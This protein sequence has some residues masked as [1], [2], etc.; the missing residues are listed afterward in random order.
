MASLLGTGASHGKQRG[1]RRRSRLAACLLFILAAYL[2]IAFS[3]CGAG[4]ADIGPGPPEQLGYIIK[5]GALSRVMLTTT[6]G[7]AGESL[8]E[9]PGFGERFSISNDG[10]YFTIVLWRED[11][12]FEGHATSLIIATDGSSGLT[13][14][15]D[16]VRP[17]F[18]P[19][20]SSVAYYTMAT[21]GP[22]SSTV[23]A[24][25]I[26]SGRVTA[27][28]HGNILE[29][30]VWSDNANIVYTEKD[31]GVIYRLDTRTGTS[32]PLTPPDRKFS[33]YTFPVSMERSRIA[34]AEEGTL[35]NIWSLDLKSGRLEQVT[36]NTRL[37]FRVGYLPGTDKILFEEQSNEID[38]D[39]SELAI[40]ADDGSDFSMLT[41]N[42]Y[43]DGLQTVSPASGR[44]AWQHSE[45]GINSIRVGVPGSRNA[46]TIVSAPDWLGDPNFLQVPSWTE[47]NPLGLSVETSPAAG[48]DGNHVKVLI[49]NPEG[50]P[51]EAV[52][53]AFS[54]PDLAEPQASEWRLSL[55]PGET[56]VIELNARVRPTVSEAR[57][58]T[59]LL[60]LAVPGAPPRMFWENLGQA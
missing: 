22:G 53:R 18:S 37:Q 9:W 34:L 33:N 38:K 60:T 39:S 50:R 52:L 12:G 10:R 8:L 56:R 26:A 55:E 35:H 20:S 40:V 48:E 45:N 16:A 3:G 27:Q 13:I 23:C 25:D 42:Y 32:V 11:A 19:D 49:S 31:S 2:A 43:F 21:D 59:L 54:G 51:A 29:D 28:A 14:P 58:A 4:S 17:S 30:P 5:S 44:I 41:S 7:G 46:A 1:T 15:G 47:N 57:Q 24:Y 36:N 6:A